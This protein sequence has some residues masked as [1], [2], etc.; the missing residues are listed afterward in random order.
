[1]YVTDHVSTRRSC[2][3]EDLLLLGKRRCTYHACQAN[4]TDVARGR[5]P[6]QD[7][8]RA[9][10]RLNGWHQDSPRETPGHPDDGGAALTA[11]SDIGMVRRL[12]DQA[13]LVA[14]KT[15]R[16]HGKSWAEV[17]TKLGVS[18]QSAWERWRDLDDGAAA[19]AVAAIESVVAEGADAVVESVT[20]V[21]AWEL[22]MLAQKDAMI[23]PNVVGMSWDDARHA[24]QRAR[25]VAVGADPDGPPL[26]A[27]GWPSGVV[28]EQKPVAGMTLPPGSPVTLW[29][30]NGGGGSA[31]VREPRRPNPPPRSA[32]E[33]RDE[34]SG[35]AIG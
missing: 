10:E 20:E 18:R 33:M 12:L 28:I 8:R 30:A 3:E 34:V 17:A 14:V 4:L 31:G 27:I 24:L 13:E 22:T 15:A 25:L 11:L 7:G 5:A 2:R 9:W 23:V 29:I 16:G 21:A 32:T 19:H 6:W 35:D 1:M 26:A